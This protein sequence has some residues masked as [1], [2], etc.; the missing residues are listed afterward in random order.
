MVFNVPDYSYA[1]FLHEHGIGERVRWSSSNTEIADVQLEPNPFTGALQPTT[2]GRFE[3]KKPGRCRIIAE[4]GGRRWTYNLTVIER[5]RPDLL[6]QFISRSPRYERIA[7]KDRPAPGDPVEFEVHVANRGFAPS[8]PATVKLSVYESGGLADLDT[9]KRRLIQLRKRIPALQVGEQTRVRFPWTWREDPCH[10]VATIA[11]RQPEIS[12]HNN[13]RSY[14]TNRSRNIYLL[15]D[16]ESWGI[17]QDVNDNHTGSF[18]LEDWLEAQRAVWDRLLREAIYPATS[19]YG[20]QVRLHIDA[21]I[22]MHEDPG[23]LG[24]NDPGPYWDGGW[25]C[26]KNWTGPNWAPGV[27]WSLMHEWG[28][29]AFAGAD[30]YSFG[31]WAPWVYIEDESGNR[32]AGT[33]ALPATGLRESRSL[34]YRS[35]DETPDGT[36]GRYLCETMMSFCGPQLHEGFAGHIQHNFDLRAQGIWQI[37]RRAVPLI[38]N[39][40]VVLDIEGNPVE[41]A[42]IAVYQQSAGI[43]ANSSH[44]FW[45]NVIKFA[46]RTNAE[47]EWAYPYETAPSFDDPDTDV[48]EGETQVASFLSTAVHPWPS[49]P[50]VYSNNS[51]QIIAVRKGPWTE[52]HVLDSFQVATE[53]YRNDRLKGAYVIQTNLPPALDDVETKPFTITPAQDLNE[54]PVVVVPEVV[55]VDPGAQ[56]EIDAG[57]SYDPEGRPVTVYW[58]VNAWRQD[59]QIAKLGGSIDASE[60]P[61]LEFTAPDKPCEVVVKVYCHDTVRVSEQKEVRI[62]VGGG[63]PT[64]QAKGN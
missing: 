55:H 19:P 58:I 20:I 52:Y 43:E 53:A 8:R 26:S 25:I 10:I 7:L 56:A 3:I 27:E 11:T 18:A 13:E 63:P 33:G 5:N 4:M 51:M 57:Q 16:P 62:I 64:D 39:S 47:G 32:V 15:I 29:G 34:I 21:L 41:G 14:L 1:P 9:R 60:G 37:H 24:K 6:V 28:H 23:D 12:T 30:L 44:S 17:W 48:V 36:N 61:V 40:I 35:S 59:S 45:P 50:G 22:E 31:I 46:G 38:Q 2:S 42:E 49:T 54:R